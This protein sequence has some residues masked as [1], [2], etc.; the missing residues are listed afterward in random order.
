MCSYKNANM[1]TRASA[2]AKPNSGVVDRRTHTRTHK[3]RSF[4]VIDNI[5]AGGWN[6]D[7]TCVLRHILQQFQWFNRKMLCSWHSP[8][9]FMD[10]GETFRANC[11]LS[12]RRTNIQLQHRNVWW[13]VD[14]HGR[15]R[16]A[17]S[18][19][20]M[21]FDF[22][23]WPQAFVDFNFDIP[24]FVNSF[25]AKGRLQQPLDSIPNPFHSNS[26][27]CAQA[28]SCTQAAETVTNELF[29]SYKNIYNSNNRTANAN[30]WV[31]RFSFTF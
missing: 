19:N 6:G 15:D 29:R 27:V 10:S 24:K 2:N 21:T 30:L 4:E 13:C 5:V 7:S 1:N 3:K 9:E 23:M 11:L 12:L 20:A 14:W 22:T 28:H 25:V 26:G 31:H 17:P 16:D 8:N 18:P